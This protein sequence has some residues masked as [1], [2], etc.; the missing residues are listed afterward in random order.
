MCPCVCLNV[1]PLTR[2]EWNWVIG[3][4]GRG[5]EKTMGKMENLIPRLDTHSQGPTVT[6]SAVRLWRRCESC[7]PVAWGQLAAGSLASFGLLA[8]SLR[9]RVE[10]LPALQ[11]KAD[12]APSAMWA[13]NGPISKSDIWRVT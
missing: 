13:D 2:L 6:P 5:C 3:G 9:L 8:A 11:A 4:A 12:L 10:L 7:S 1:Y